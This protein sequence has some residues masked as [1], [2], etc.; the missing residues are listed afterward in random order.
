MP[1]SCLVENERWS[2]MVGPLDKV[3]HDRFLQLAYTLMSALP[4]ACFVQ[5]NERRHSVGELRALADWIREGE[6]DQ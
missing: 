3:Q 2:R 4:P 6:P 1:V 5:L